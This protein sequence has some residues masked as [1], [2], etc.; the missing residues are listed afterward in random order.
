MSVND[1][2]R[3]TKKGWSLLNIALPVP[4]ECGVD[5]T[6][7]VDPSGGASPRLNLPLTRAEP[8][9]G[10]GCFRR[11]AATATGSR[12]AWTVTTFTRR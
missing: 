11:L 9:P 6:N 12:A 1:V 4:E 8:G 3:I 2:G 7:R 5:S 10:S